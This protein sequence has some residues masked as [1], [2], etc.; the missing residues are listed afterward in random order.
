VQALAEF[1]RAYALHSEPLA[2]HCELIHVA[3]AAVAAQQPERAAS[4]A[5]QILREAPS[6]ERSSKLHHCFQNDQAAH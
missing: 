6:Y 3:K 2:K 1:E 4:A 5:E